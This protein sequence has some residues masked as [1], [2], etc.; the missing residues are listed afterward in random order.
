MI[1]EFGKETPYEKMN[2]KTRK[3]MGGQGNAVRMKVDGNGSESY[4]IAVLKLLALL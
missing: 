2:W 3:K 1:I 4:A